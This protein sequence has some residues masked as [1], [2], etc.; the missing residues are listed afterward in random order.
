MNGNDEAII[1]LAE[2]PECPTGPHITPAV[3]AVV[4]GIVLWPCTAADWEAFN[5]N[6]CH[7]G[8]CQV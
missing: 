5:D 1:H 3:A 2:T 6:S 8:I 4:V 7:K